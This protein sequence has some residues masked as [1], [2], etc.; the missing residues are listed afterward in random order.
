MHFIGTTLLLICLEEAIRQANPWFV[1]YGVLCGYGFAWIGHF[2]IEKN[3]PATFRYPLL[4]LLGD[5]KMYAWMWTGK[6]LTAEAQR[7]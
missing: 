7:S 5:F 6:K 1:A 3:R 4:S 2:G